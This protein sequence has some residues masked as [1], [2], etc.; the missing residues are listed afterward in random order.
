MGCMFAYNSTRKARGFWT[1]SLSTERR[2]KW[3][4]RT[5]QFISLSAS[6]TS[7]G[8]AL[9]ISCSCTIQVLVNVSLIL[10]LPFLHPSLAAHDSKRARARTHTHTQI[11]ARTHTRAHTRNH[12]D[13]HSLTH[14][15]ANP[16]THEQVCA[17][18]PLRTTRRMESRR[19]TSCPAPG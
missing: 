2:R 3:C 4:S 11:H 13:N 19:R 1:C 10:P 12:R 16:P 5:S 18:F 9:S 14:P 8:T 17:L 6:T 15:P 7:C